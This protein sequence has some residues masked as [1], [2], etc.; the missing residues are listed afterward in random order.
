VTPSSQSRLPG[1]TLPVR[2]R[3]ALPFTFLG[4]GDQ[5][6]LVAGEDFRWTLAGPGIASWLP[7]WLALLD[8]RRTLDEMLTQLAPE[9]HAAARQIL[10]HLA[11]ER[12][13]IA[14]PVEAGHSDRRH[15]LLVEGT[16]LFRAGLEALA[17]A[18]PALP[19]VAVLCQDRPDIDEVLRFN[20]RSLRSASPWLWISCAAMN[21]GYVSPVFLPDAGPCLRCLL[22]HFRRL[23]PLPELY[24]ELAE[25][26]RAGGRLAAV[27]FP[28]PAV[29]ILQQILVWKIDLLAR[30]EASAAMY[31]LHVLEAASL[32]VS[33]HPVMVDPECRAC[34][35]RR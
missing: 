11:G 27:P 3:L 20:E 16:G 1:R 31:R 17:D 9:H 29:T 30:E 19:V 22:G 10:D 7:A 32:E 23:S 26:T 33:S 34:H 24:D 4:E 12:V 18:Y 15:R 5:V 6:R 21:R 13:L 2:P 8:G 25:H 14:G 28:A 35:G